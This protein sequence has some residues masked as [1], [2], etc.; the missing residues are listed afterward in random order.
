MNLRLPGHLPYCFLYLLLCALLST[1]GLRAQ[2]IGVIAGL[3]IP[4]PS[5]DFQQ[6][7]NYPSCCP[8]FTDGS[9]SGFQF[10]G[11]YERTLTGPLSLSTRLMLSYE[12]VSFAF[13]ERSFVADLRDTPRVVPAVFR[14]GLS[15]T[16]AQIV[17]EPL[18]AL[19]FAGNGSMLFGPRLG[20]SVTSTFQQTE[21]LVE[22]ADFGSFIN[23]GRVWIDQSGDIPS[24]PALAL[25][26]TGALRWSFRLTSSGSVMML[27]ELSFSYALTPV[28]QGADW[29]PHA[30]R[31]SIALGWRPGVEQ[32]IPQRPQE[33]PLQPPAL[34]RRVTDR[35]E[36]PK[37]TLRI[38][39]VN[40]DGTTTPDPVISRREVFI[41]TLHPM[42]GNV[43]FDEGSWQI[44]ERYL[45][46]IDR[47]RRD[48]LSLGPLEA[49]HGELAII[50]ARMKNRPQARLRVGGMTANTPRDQGA[51]L[52][53]RRAESVRDK[54]IALGIEPQRIELI[55]SSG[56]FPA[57]RASDSLQKP[58][59]IEENQRVEVSCSDFV[60]M[61]PITLG[62]TDVSVQPRRI[63]IIDTVASSALSAVTSQI[64]IAD[65][66]MPVERTT[67]APSGI[68]DVDIGSLVASSRSS[69]LEI[70]ISA[71]DTA[72]QSST[73]NIA[74]PIRQQS[75][76]KWRAERSGDLLI[77]RYGLVLFEFNNAGLSDQHRKII[78]IIRS[79]IT[80]QT[81]VSILG[82]TDVLGSDEY[83][84]DLSQRRAKEVSRA[85]G[86]TSV[87]IDARGESAPQFVNDLPEGRA[88]NRT[89]VIELKTKVP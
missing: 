50:A 59:A 13:D 40:D 53:R 41:R 54:L 25:A 64:Q 23:T 60:V 30:V 39:G 15:S 26:L 86:V 51:A 3:T 71:T 58:L 21:S 77:E 55:P 81:T 63:R 35:P 9:G 70:R 48:T 19:R 20:A 79:R 46:G 10:G 34:V 29:Y 89:V 69:S 27:P 16:Q 67:S 2:P 49:L 68:E 8:R 24:T 11:W 76:E 61:A 1:P 28:S 83:N 47:A 88:S 45:R 17:I 84:K 80:P 73:E 7:G 74:V 57:T 44:P 78:D 4:V 5:A 75:V 31:L 38:L 82:M 22:P 42:L 85:L 14:H 56:L 66:R 37:I 72:G 87:T 36:P 32:P 62:T 6:L 43:Y 52:A 18:L 33:P 12:N 65:Q